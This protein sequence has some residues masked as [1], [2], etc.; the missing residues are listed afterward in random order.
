MRFLCSIQTIDML[1]G[2]VAQ[3]GSWKETVDVSNLSHLVHGWVVVNIAQDVNSLKSQCS[4]TE[5]A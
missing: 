3:F 1:K 5:I 2:P 4:Q